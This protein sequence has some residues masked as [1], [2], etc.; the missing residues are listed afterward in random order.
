MSVGS[1]PESPSG[2]FWF[3]IGDWLEAAEHEADHGEA[4]ERGGFAGVTFVVASEPA[5]AADP[6]QR[7]LHDPAFGEHDEAVPVTAANDLQVPHAGAG[8]GDLHLL[9]LI[10]RVGDD[11]LDKRE[12]PSSLPEQRLGAV[13]VLD[14]GRVD[15]DG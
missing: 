2:K 13:P 15:A 1:R 5:T 9:P 14:A 8:Y 10:A 6:C 7:P 11:A 12:A 4:D 3:L